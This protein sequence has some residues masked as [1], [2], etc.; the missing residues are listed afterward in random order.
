[1][2]KNV[3]T[4]F[5]NGYDLIPTKDKNLKISRF[6]LVNPIKKSKKLYY[7]LFFISLIILILFISY[8][9]FR[10]NNGTKETINYIEDKNEINITEIY[11]K[12]LLK[13]K[14]T[15]HKE[16]KDCYKFVKKAVN[17]TLINP[18]ETFYRPENP[19][20]SIVIPMYNAEGYIENGIFAI[21]NQDFKDIEII[22]I[23]DC[24]KDNSV[25]VVNQLMKK[26]PRINLYQNKETKGTLYSKS[27][28]VKYS[29][30]KYVL[31]SDQDDLYTQEDAFSTMYYH[32]E[33]DNLDILGFAAL[34]SGTSNI[35]KRPC[36]YLFKNTKIYHQPSISGRMYYVG[37][38]KVRRI[39]DVIWN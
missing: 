32:L 5:N 14:R 16:L 26:E 2:L 18:N 17:H 31:V 25:Q 21:E 24:S 20:I 9:F 4:L 38:K 1:M 15:L 12:M 36:L 30:G 28:G 3:M 6:H 13:G 22:I 19:K 29:K 39:G 27:L 8:L 34:F 7:I 35:K 37:N 11:N 23:D 33:K 10:V